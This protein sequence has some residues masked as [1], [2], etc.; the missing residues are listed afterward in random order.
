MIQLPLENHHPFLP[1]ILLQSGFTSF[2]QLDGTAVAARESKAG[3]TDEV[4]HI[5]LNSQPASVALTIEQCWCLEGVL[6]VLLYF[7][8][9]LLWL[10]TDGP[11][12]F[13]RV[14]VGF[15]LK[16]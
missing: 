1:R 6:I 11:A 3:R 12:S 7:D 2:L 10:F 14:A 8:Y 16:R 15:V 4:L 9:G 13:L 5:V